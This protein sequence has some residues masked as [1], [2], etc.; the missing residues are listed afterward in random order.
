MV[1]EWAAR[2]PPANPTINTRTP[3]ITHL[4]QVPRSKQLSEML[5][6][7]SVDEGTWCEV[8]DGGGG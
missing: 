7:L 5:A 8:G 6:S 1:V 4:T 3:F 2:G